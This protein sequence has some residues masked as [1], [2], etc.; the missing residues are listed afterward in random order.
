MS[1]LLNLLQ[2][3]PTRNDQSLRGQPGPRFE[4]FPTDQTTSRIQALTVGGPSNNPLNA[5]QSSEDL[6]TGRTIVRRGL[7]P[8]GAPGVYPKAQSDEPVSFPNNRV[9][10]PFYRVLNA[11]GSFINPYPNTNTYLG[12]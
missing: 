6:L 10:K 12:G 3:G 11:A 4:T 5:I 2:A 7:G 1:N 8:G 9:G